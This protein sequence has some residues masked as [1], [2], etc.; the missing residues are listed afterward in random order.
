MYRV[1]LTDEQR[2]QLNRRAHQP[3]IAPS[4][5]DRLEM[6]RLSD[7]GWRIPRIAVHLSQHE[8]T[9]RY[10]I[11]AFLTGSFDAL[12]NKPRG[13]AISALTPEVLLAVQKEVTTSERTW[14]ADQIGDFIAARFG[15]QR[16]A[17]QIRRKLRQAHMSYKRTGR[18]LHHK[19]K[20]EEVATKRAE[21]A[22]LEKGGPR[23]S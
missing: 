21:L 14:N 3:G 4:T 17:D 23:T 12:G 9:V 15:I 6:V 11:K 20:P 1:M 13:G 18:H 8:Q 5:R 22:V 10:W 2:Q 7:A 16:S 19:Q